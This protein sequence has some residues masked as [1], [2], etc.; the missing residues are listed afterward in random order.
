MKRN[1]V[2]YTIPFF[3][4][5]YVWD[6][7]NWNQLYD[8]LMSDD[9]ANFLGAIILKNGEYVNDIMYKSV[10][11]GQQRLTTISILARAINDEYYHPGGD[12]IIPTMESIIYNVDDVEQDDGNIVHKRAI[13]IRHSR[14]DSE[15]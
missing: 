9:E 3:Q 8:S 12:Q 15:K 6:K 2:V 10:I 11:D 4:R 1:S 13:K 5:G 14:K 7:D